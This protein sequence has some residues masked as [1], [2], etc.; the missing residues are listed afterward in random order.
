MSPDNMT[1]LDTA[2]NMNGIEHEFAE[3]MKRAP[4]EQRDHFRDTL[5]ML[6]QCYGVRPPLG[7]MAGVVDKRTGT[8]TVHG[9]NLTADEMVTVAQLS[10]QVIGDNLSPAK[11]PNEVH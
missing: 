5:N 8:L 6:M 2:V 11:T 4:Q 3:F 7:V 1:P 9:I 10:L